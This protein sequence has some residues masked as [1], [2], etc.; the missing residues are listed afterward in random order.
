MAALAGLRAIP[1]VLGFEIARE[2]S[3]KNHFDYAVSMSFADQ[4]AYNLYNDHPDHVAFVAERWV[5]E[6]AEFM[7]HDTV[8]LHLA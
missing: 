7:E 6:V 3:P 8:A 4:A 5:P 2:I 1:G